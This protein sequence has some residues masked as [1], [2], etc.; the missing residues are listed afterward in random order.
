M[1]KSSRILILVF[2]SLF[3]TVMYSADEPFN[4]S[5]SSGAF[6]ANA[7][8]QDAYAMRLNHARDE[9]HLIANRSLEV[10]GLP[11]VGGGYDL[12]F[13]MCD[14][15]FWKF[16]IQTGGGLSNA[17]PYGELLWGLTV[18]IIPIWLPTRPPRYLPHLRLDFATHLLFSQL[19]PSTWLYPIWL[20]VGVPL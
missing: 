7:G 16:F 14:E 4:L 10:G 9:F 6:A 11:L 2:V 3:S 13:D 12:K 5:L 1:W 15:C 8:G 20:G 17:G 19:R 18:P